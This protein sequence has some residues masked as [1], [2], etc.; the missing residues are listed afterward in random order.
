MLLRLRADGFADADFPGSFGDGDEHDV[1]HADAAHQQSHRSDREHQHENQI[2]DFVPE[3]EKVV[4]S[5]NRE[6][7]RL[8]IG[9]AAFSAQQVA[10][11]LDGLP[12]DF[13]IAGFGENDVI[14]LDWDRASAGW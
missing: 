6:V 7:V 14:L 9:E 13:R 2:A 12:D 11:F 10:D 3:I 8:V 1:H 5:E 4:G